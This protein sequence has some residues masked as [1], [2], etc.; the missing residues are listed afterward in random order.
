MEA[1]GQTDQENGP[2]AENDKTKYRSTAAKIELDAA[3]VPSFAH[4]H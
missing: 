3:M 1:Y 2:K 4:A